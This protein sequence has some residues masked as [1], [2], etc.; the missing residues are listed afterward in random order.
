MASH[1]PSPLCSNPQF[2]CISSF[3]TTATKT[4]FG[5]YAHVPVSSYRIHGGVEGVW[6][7]LAH[8]KTQGGLN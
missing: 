2:L 5:V 3:H 6:K 7:G 4:D 1:H 8:A